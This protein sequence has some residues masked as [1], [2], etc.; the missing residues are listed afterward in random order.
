M[1]GA[2]R[3][4]LV[5][6]AASVVLVVLGAGVANAYTTNGARIGYD[7]WYKTT[8]SF[9]DETRLR[10][11]SAMQAWNK[12]LPE[13]KRVCYD[14]TYAAEALYPHQNACNTIT[15]ISSTKSYT[16]ENHM[17]LY[18][19]GSR[20]VLE[21]D[22]N[23]NARMSWWNDPPSG[24]YDPKSALIHEFGHT[25]GLGHS[26]VAYAVMSIPLYAGTTNSVLRADDVNGIK[27]LY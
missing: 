17:W 3:K 26:S 8:N 24:Y 23:V 9:T 22:I 10:A 13:G 15:K 7:V 20:R 16:S 12:Y 14:S 1:K 21:S 25:A 4:A 5:V 27:S 18:A 2:L 6:I 19:D 11:R